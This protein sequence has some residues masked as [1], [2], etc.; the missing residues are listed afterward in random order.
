MFIYFAVLKIQQLTPKY[1]ICN[2][3]Q[4]FRSVTKIAKT[5]TTNHAHWHVLKIDQWKEVNI[6]EHGVR[7]RRKEE[8]SVS[9]REFLH[10]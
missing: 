4:F 7:W 9:L 5:L 3:S 6:E 10:V 1:N 2:W 8:K